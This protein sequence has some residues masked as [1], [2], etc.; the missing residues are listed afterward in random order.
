MLIFYCSKCVN[1]RV[2]HTEIEVALW[3]H[4]LAPISVQIWNKQISWLC[5]QISF[6]DTGWKNP[7][8][9]QYFEWCMCSAPSSYSLSI[10]KLLSVDMWQY[11]EFHRQT[12]IPTSGIQFALWKQPWCCGSYSDAIQS[13]N[14]ESSASAGLLTVWKRQWGPGATSGSSSCRLSE[15]RLLNI[16]A[17]ISS[18]SLFGWNMKKLVLHE[19]PPLISLLSFW[20]LHH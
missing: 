20:H 17:L 18:S 10:T 14:K 11:L 16:R 1:T 19:D 7:Y 2:W 8:L 15:D 6:M 13:T 5:A 3:I 12:N 9:G 4:H